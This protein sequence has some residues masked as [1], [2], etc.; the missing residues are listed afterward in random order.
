M[1]IKKIGY[2]STWVFDVAVC[3]LGDAGEGEGL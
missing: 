2:S 1:G 3:Q